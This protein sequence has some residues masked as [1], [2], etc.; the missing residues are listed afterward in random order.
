MSRLRRVCAAV[1]LYAVVTLGI[2]GV[3]GMGPIATA[4]PPPAAASA[5][6]NYGA[7]IA[8]QG[9][10][11]LLLMIDE[12]AS[13][14]QSDPG[15][16]RVTAAKYLIDRLASY[17]D[18]NHLAVDVAIAGFSTDFT[19][20]RGWT[21][22]TPQNADDLKAV[23]DRFANRV[24][25][26]DTDYLTALEAARAYLAQRP[27]GTGNAPRCQAI[28]WFTDG[29]FDFQNRSGLSVPYAPGVD[30]STEAGV[31]EAV[32]LGANQ[33]CRP[34]GVADQIRSSGIVIFGV[35]LV[36]GGAQTP[37][38]TDMRRIVEGSAAGAGDCGAVKSPKPGDFHEASDIDQLLFAFDQ[39]S[40]P[41]QQPTVH[42]TGVC[43]G[44][45]CDTARHNFTLDDSIDFVDLLAK[46]DPSLVPYLVS[47]A[48]EQLRIP[49][50]NEPHVDQLTIAGAGVTY[51]WETADTV[52]ISLSKPNAPWSGQ[53]ALTFVDE[54][55]AGTGVSQSSISLEAGVRPARLDQAALAAGQTPAP[56][57][58]QS[59]ELKFG[60]VDRGG[61]TKDSSSLLGEVSLTIDLVPPGG[62]P[63]P[64]KFA[65]VVLSKAEIGQPLR[66]DLSRVTAGHYDM[67]LGLKLSTAPTVD[68]AGAAVPGTELVTVPIRLPI[69][70]GPA[71]GYPTIATALDFGQSSRAG[72]V[73]AKLPVTGPGCVWI[74]KATPDLS[75]NP[76]GVGAVTVGAQRDGS[77]REKCLNLDDGKNGTIDVELTTE[78]EAKGALTGTFVVSSVSNDAPDKVVN[79]N[80]NLTLELTK[81]LDTQTFWLTLLLA[82]LLGPGLPLL[83]LYAAKWLTA[84]IPAQPLLA[85]EIPVMIDAGTV[86]RDGEPFAL[87]ER[88]LVDPVPGLHK[89]TRR[90]R[91]GSIELAT[92]IGRSPFGSGYVAAQK[93]MLLSASSET[94][95]SI[96]SPPRARLPLAIHNKWIVVSDP[97]WAPDRAAVILMTSGMTDQTQRDAIAGDLARRLPALLAELRSGTPGSIP[98]GPA[99]AGPGI[100]DPFGPGGGDPFGPGGSDPFGPGGSD[101]FGPGGGDSH[102]P[103]STG[104]SVPPSAPPAPFG[105]PP[106]PP[107]YSGARSDGPPPPPPPPQYGGSP[108]QQG[109]QW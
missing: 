16:A 1:A 30:M 100:G 9:T 14:R 18:R 83:L 71:V 60:L 20:D 15:G 51:K 31:A 108:D 13:L 66:L 33:I 82:L 76:A 19:V 55:G 95:A 62:V 89:P 37:N 12:S 48:N 47:P 91:V 57:P 46:S 103:A 43:A 70:I 45:V 77:S 41:G 28:G 84:R 35:G 81:S 26:N 5:I 69:D 59:Q 106:P 99:G 65:P 42:D 22:V 39:L 94:P 10:G 63:D 24:D 27:H 85:V 4:V 75:G 7:C 97:S 6:T 49:I 58:S 105:G 23:V 40:T 38:F 90:L 74:E 98:A 64:A 25:G 92:H 61:Q 36:G 78:N 101:L 44:T 73:T 102:A 53:W 87:R 56:G 68:S 67:A 2:L 79:Q 72:T 34:G 104:G 88:D 96:G 17:A 11:D 29:A 109:N 21:P 80:V 107:Q 93:T 52:R 50:Q 86:L 32:S 54:G 3:G 8:G